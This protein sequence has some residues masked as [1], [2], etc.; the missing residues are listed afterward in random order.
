MTVTKWTDL[1]REH[2]QNLIRIDTTNPPG[3]ETAACRYIADV[4]D[5]AGIEHRIYEPEP[6]RGSIVARLRGDGSARPLLLLSHLDVVPAEP[7]EWSRDPFGGELA[8]GEVWGRGALDCKGAVALW[9]TVLL[10]AKEEGLRLKRDIIFAATADEEAGGSLG[11]GWLVENH[12]EELDAEY[13]LNEG[14]GASMVLGGRTFFTYQTAEKG[15]CWLRLR[16]RGVGGHA[17]VPH[18]ENA[19][20]RLA[21][22]VARLGRSSLPV[23]LTET[24]ERFLRGIAEG[25][26][27]DLDLSDPVRQA[28]ALAG[29]EYQALTFLAMLRNTAC[30]TVLRAGSKTNVIPSGAE[31]DV[32]C[33]LLPGQGPEDV[34]RE[35]REV[36][37]AEVL[38]HLEL[39]VVRSGQPNWSSADTE[40]AAVIG[41][42]LEQKRPGSVLV[43]L[44]V[45]GATDARYLRSRGTT[46][47]GFVPTLPDVDERSVHGVNERISLASLAFGL[48]VGWE[49]VRRM[50]GVERA[51]RTP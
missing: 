13:C 30:P 25:L 5:R 12:P 21:E 14:G 50:T 8:E 7:E 43:P 27:R 45:P 51:H 1:L 16:A 46:V 39:E 34:L 3:G 48:E 10:R 18:G 32:D 38:E 35:V 19:V 36:L 42:V 9:L 17:S 47:Y 2:L 15:I 49:V 22:A 6:G 11:V 37:G 23:H 26:G 20:V 40:L 44:L 41:E 24:P 29:D 33:R 31:A 4:L 28:R